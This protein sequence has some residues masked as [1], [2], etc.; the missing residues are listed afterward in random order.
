[1]KY[2][3]SKKGEIYRSSKQV[4]DN[5]AEYWIYEEYHPETQEAW[6]MIDSNWTPRLLINGVELTPYAEFMECVNFIL[7]SKE[8]SDERKRKVLASL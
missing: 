1:M 5:G 2:Y 8:I 3:W 7:I 4:Y 6:H